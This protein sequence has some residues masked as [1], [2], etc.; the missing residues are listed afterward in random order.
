MR[1]ATGALAAVIAAAS[2]LVSCAN[3]GEK[4]LESWAPSA[5]KKTKTATVTTVPEIEPEETVTTKKT[6]KTTAETEPPVTEIPTETSKK[7]ETFTISRISIPKITLRTRPADESSEAQPANGTVSEPDQHTGTEQ[8][9]TITWR[10]IDGRYDL[11]V[12]VTYF[13]EDY[14]YFASLP[15]DNDPYHCQKY[16]DDEY[17]RKFLSQIANAIRD[18]CS[19]QGYDEIETVKEAVRFV[20]S[21]PYKQDV[22]SKGELEYFKYPI[23]TIAENNGDCED[24]SMLLAGILREMGYGTCFFLF[25]T[26]IAVGVKGSESVPGMYY[27]QDGVRYYFIETTDFGWNIGDFPDE[28]YKDKDSIIYI[29]ITN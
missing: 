17:N 23:E 7:K 29:P 8:T 27:V 14:N 20:Q 11:S 6:K 21:V 4:E 26:H 13:R 24:L 12:T 5:E 25:P 15:R 2:M 19:K 16:I 9:R 3:L 22:E 18:V 10:T 28:L 1:K